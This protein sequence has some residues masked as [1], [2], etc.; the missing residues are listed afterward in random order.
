[1]RNFCFI[2]FLTAI[3]L[4]S[5]GC[6]RENPTTSASH[7]QTA[8]ELSKQDLAGLISLPPDEIELVSVKETTADRAP[9]AT[10]YVVVLKA[11]GWEYK[12][13]AGESEVIL[14]DISP[15]AHPDNT[16]TTAR[17]GETNNV[18][19]VP[20]EGLSFP[21]DTNGL[22]DGKPWMPVN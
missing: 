18:T 5:P 16:R 15:A 7:A 13:T 12:Y 3:L 1:M 11:D 2:L 22:M 21:V 20:E 6:P 9:K 8:V 17:P 19:K 10:R 14:S 4:T